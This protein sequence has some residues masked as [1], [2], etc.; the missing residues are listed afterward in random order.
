M[1]RP[2]RPPKV[3]QP[4]HSPPQ[5]SAPKLRL[6]H[7]RRP[8]RH[9]SRGPRWL[10]VRLLPPRRPI[11]PPNVPRPR[12]L[13]PRMP[14]RQRHQPRVWRSH[15]PG[16]RRPL[17]RASVPLPPI[18]HARHRVPVGQQSPS[19]QPG[20]RRPSQPRAPSSRGAARLQFSL[21]HSPL[22]PPP[23]HDRLRPSPAPRRRGGAPP[24]LLSPHSRPSSRA[25]EAQFRYVQ[26]RRGPR[27]LPR[28]PLAAQ[29]QPRP[30]SLP[31]PS[32]S[33]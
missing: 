14:Q 33:P 13:R 12:G 32:P 30:G 5:A 10:V 26:S 15:L 27:P 2:P 8:C 9:C 11:L 7:T 21:P 19:L 24:P 16:R 17:T 23:L 29:T 3:A 31:R 4:Q 28:L 6:R 20:D 25:P 22:T 1:Q 18:R